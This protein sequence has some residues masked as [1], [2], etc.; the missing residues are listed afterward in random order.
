MQ[1]A[2]EFDDFTDKQRQIVEDQF[3]LKFIHPPVDEMQGLPSVE[4]ITLQAITP[5]SIDLQMHVIN[6]ESAS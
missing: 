4:G 2:D 3:R 5:T 1:P 6:P